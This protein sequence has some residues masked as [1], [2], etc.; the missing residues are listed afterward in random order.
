MPVSPL[1]PVDVAPSLSAELR[2]RTAA[3]HDGAEASPFFARLVAGQVCTDDVAALLARL[4][5]VYD[6]LEAAASGWADDPVVRPLV[7]PGLERAGRI[8]AD[9][10]ALG[11]SRPTVSPAS[12]EYAARVVE[13]A[14]ASRPGFVAHHYTRY[15]GDLSGGQVMRA[16]LQ[17]ALGLDSDN[18]GSFFVFEGMRPGQVKQHY[19]AALDALPF[20]DAEREELVAEA[21]V[22]YRLNTALARELDLTLGAPA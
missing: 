19:R 11:L 2:A 18:G 10:A 4:L 5:P 12:A 3:A 15:L 16:A 6:A 9:L 17:R 14:S 13:V 22:A 8:R 21:L 7:V 1:G 20:G